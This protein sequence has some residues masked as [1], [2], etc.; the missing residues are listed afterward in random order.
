[1]EGKGSEHVCKSST[2]KLPSF[3]KAVLP[4]G[5]VSHSVI[6][7]RKWLSRYLTGLNVLTR[8]KRDFLSHFKGE[9]MRRG[10]VLLLL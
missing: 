2:L 9:E 10:V 7:Q 6:L 8:K 4:L 5:V 1:M 3:L